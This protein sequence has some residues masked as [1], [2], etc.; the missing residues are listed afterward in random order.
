MDRACVPKIHIRSASSDAHPGW[1]SWR[2]KAEKQKLTKVLPWSPSLLQRVALE[3]F[4][5]KYVCNKLFHSMTAAFKTYG[6]SSGRF[7]RECSQKFTPFIQR[8]WETGCQ[9]LLITGALCSNIN[10]LSLPVHNYACTY[11]YAFMSSKLQS[12]KGG[13]N[14]QNTKWRTHCLLAVDFSFICLWLAFICWTQPYAI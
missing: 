11:W 9:W 2:K 13:G 10:K 5:Q 4:V 14:L 3:D 7:L 1:Y 6:R 8:V 12:H